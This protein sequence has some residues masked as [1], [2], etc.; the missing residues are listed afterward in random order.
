MHLLAPCCKVQSD[1]THNSNLKIS[2]LFIVPLLR[3]L[4]YP[5]SQ[6]SA[7]AACNEGIASAW[8]SYL[9]PLG[10]CAG[11]TSFASC[12]GDGKFILLLF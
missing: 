7:S 2:L 8:M 11:S 10:Q 5:V 4:C 6:Y 3:D 1:M 9:Y 12:S